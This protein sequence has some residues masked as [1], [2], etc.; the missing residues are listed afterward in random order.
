MILDGKD[1]FQLEAIG[2]NWPAFTMKDD[3]PDSLV[4]CGIYGT[5]FV[6]YTTSHRVD[7]N[8]RTPRC[9]RCT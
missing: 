1:V 4:L 7:E 3:D 2:D 6:E 8:D 9:S 5:R